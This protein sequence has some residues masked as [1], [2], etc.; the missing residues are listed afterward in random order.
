MKYLEVEAFL[1]N[2]RKFPLIDVRSP[3]EYQK[4]H[5]GGAINIPLFSDRERAIVGTVY[6]R[7]GQQE[8]ILRGLQI[9]SPKLE[10]FKS[11]AKKIADKGQ[12]LVHCWR[13]GMRSEKMALLF[14]KTGLNCFVLRGGYKAYRTKL[15]GDFTEIRKLVVLEGPTGSGKTEIL[16]NM[17]EMGAQIIDLEGLARHRGSTF[18]WIGQ[19]EQPTTAQF[20]N[21]IYQQLLMLDNDKP[22]WVEGESLKIGK[23][24]LPETLWERMNN[25][26]IVNIELDKNVRRQ[27]IVEE[28]G[29]FSRG[30]LLASLQKI[31][32]GL[33]NLN[34]SLVSKAITED[35]LPEAVDILLGYYD[36]SYLY[37]LKKYRRKTPIN[38]IL[39]KNDSRASA[40]DIIQKTNSILFE[41]GL[42]EKS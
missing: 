27:R 12:L 32:P 33:G 8:A 38:I 36:K 35:E 7:E 11:L 31:R 5:I 6:A 26:E 3:G 41:R 30:D 17:A 39:N 19:K 25:A 14:E 23:V 40:V 9:V 22:I 2:T 13:G 21:D 1:K 10:D 15:R 29:R 28:Y 34:Y 18:G 24:T 42:N 16:K 37:S 4:G 20:Q